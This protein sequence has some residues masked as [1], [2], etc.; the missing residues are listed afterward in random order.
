MQDAV[1]DLARR[2]TIH[3]ETIRQGFVKVSLTGVD[4]ELIARTVNEM[5]DAF[6]A[7]TLNMRKRKTTEV[8]DVLEK[9]LE[10]AT[11]QLARSEQI[12]RGFREKHPTVGLSQTASMSVENAMNLETASVQDGMTVGDAENLRRQF[13]NAADHERQLV[14][15]E[16]LSFLGAHGVPAAASMRIEYNQ[17]VARLMELRTN[18]AQRHP[19]VQ[20]QHEKLSRIGRRA[21]EA[22]EDFIARV[23]DRIERHEEK[24]SEL[25]GK[26]RSL[27]RKEL[28]LA[29][30]E[31]QRQ[32]A[33]EIHAMV[34][35]R[36]NQAK[37]A[38]AVEVPDMYVMD[39]AMAPIPPP[40]S[41]R[42]LLRVLMGVL[43]GLTASFG[44]V[45]TADMIDKTARTQHE[46][47]RLADIPVLE[48]V[49]VIETRNAKA[50]TGFNDGGGGD[51]GID[52]KLTTADYAPHYIN[53]IYRSLRT[54][55]LLSMH[56]IGAKGLVVT[57]L[58]MDEGKSLTAAN[59]AITMA[60]RH[61]KTVLVDADLRRGV[62]HST[63]GINKGRGLTDLL[64]PGAGHCAADIM[65]VA[66]ATHVP[67]L[68]LMS[69]GASAPNPLELLS[70]PEFASVITTLRESFDIVIFDT[71]PLGVASDAVV[72]M[73][74]Q[75][76]CLF[77]VRAGK[78]NTIDVRRKLEE[79][80][81]LH[82]KIIG[83]VLNRAPV[84]RRLRYYKYS[85]YN[86]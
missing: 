6:I 76:K 3:R 11:A 50:V 67:G 27:P 24:I 69:T 72:L 79:Y 38:N 39:Y 73:Q 28:R 80:P 71:P 14:I 34:Q 21:D 7:R 78:T 54:K 47:M 20:E 53:E 51:R 63:F 82:E 42:I 77:V 64:T 55:L 5:A 81:V 83:A 70:S 22:L 37:I 41:V 29:K 8:I 4:Y 48:T 61:L 15:G 44:P 75:E 74:H 17:I 18:Y 62:Q 31:R 9:Q 85:N 59:V 16:M 84:D 60:Q 2:V 40:D 13:R 32:V 35:S 58:D 66:H 19:I 33:S 49:P 52:E 1:D 68:T 12:M 46:F 86:Y 30:L 10:T 56:E 45:L 36:Y 25:T 26:L 65:S 23:T 43:L 57:S